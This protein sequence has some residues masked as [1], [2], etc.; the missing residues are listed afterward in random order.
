[1]LKSFKILDSS[2]SDCGSDSEHSHSCEHKDFHMSQKI[3]QRRLTKVLEA[4][5]LESDDG[6]INDKSL[7]K[8]PLKMGKAK[9]QFL[10]QT[11]ALDRY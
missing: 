1:M 10:G 9:S 3:K 4:E 6:S 8:S 7:P 5:E 11:G 2:D